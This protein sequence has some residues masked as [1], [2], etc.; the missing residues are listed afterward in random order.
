MEYYNKILGPALWNYQTK[1]PI[2]TTGCD[3]SE[4]WN[5]ITTRRIEEKAR[6]FLQ[7]KVVLSQ[8]KISGQTDGGNSCSVYILKEHEV[9][10]ETGSEKH[11]F[12]FNVQV[13]RE[14]NSKIVCVCESLL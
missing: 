5:R 7:K 14:L 11:S 4:I 8:A 10:E 12:D 3:V 6:G 13:H 1:L 2:N 9:N